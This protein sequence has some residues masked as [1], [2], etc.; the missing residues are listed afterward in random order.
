MQPSKNTVSVPKETLFA[1]NCTLAIVPVTAV[2]V[3]V[4]VVLELTASDEPVVGALIATV[5]WLPPV[6]VMV[7]VDEVVVA[8]R[9][10]VTTAVRNNC[11]RA[12]EST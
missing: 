11:P 9:L 8:P 6:T 4:T 7:L 2:A 1:R 10:S 12:S 5:G 3:A